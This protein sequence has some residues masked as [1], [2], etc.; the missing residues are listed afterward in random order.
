MPAERQDLSS[1][2]IVPLPIERDPRRARAPVALTGSFVILLGA[3]IWAARDLLIPITVAFLLFFAVSPMRRRLWRMGVPNWVTACAVSLGF[4]AVAASIGTMLTGQAGVLLDELP[5]ITERLEEKY[6]S[7]KDEIAG[8]KDAAETIDE[9]AE[10]VTED[11]G[12]VRTETGRPSLVMSVLGATPAILA[13]VIGTILLLFFLIASADLFYLKIV[14][15]FDTL[16]EKRK[17]Y[18]ALR[19]IEDS[20]G[21]YFASVVVINLG[22]GAA[23]AAAFWA[24]GMP[25][26]F[27]FG[28]AA[29]LLNFIPYLGPILGAGL[30]VAVALVSLD[31]LWLPAFVGAVYILAN[32]LES[33]FVTPYFLSRK[34]ELNTVVVLLSVALWGWLWSFPGMVV[35]VPILAVLRVLCEHL[36]GWEKVGNFLAG[37]AP[38]LPAEPE[39]G[40]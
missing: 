1:D 24:L 40:A 29:F 10:G 14:Q 18:T 28:V 25:S 9:V 39:K 32:V 3:A 23:I 6:R 33:E 2:P 35:A 7:V 17:A 34:L 16:A 22:F 36:P 19:Q 15:S 37:G 8:L 13:K 4:L 21:S 31:G 12:A 5:T 30:S 26:P 27:L 20:L 38:P 11:E